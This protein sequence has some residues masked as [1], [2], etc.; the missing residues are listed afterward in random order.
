MII[1]FNGRHGK[2]QQRKTV[3]LK[4]VF[5]IMCENRISH[6]ICDRNENLTKDEINQLIGI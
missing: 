4:K 1:I 2:A 3:K 5:E 6:I